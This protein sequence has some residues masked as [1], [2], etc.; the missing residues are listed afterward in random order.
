MFL[1]ARKNRY[2]SLSNRHLQLLEST[3]AGLSPNRGTAWD[4]SRESEDLI[5]ALESKELITR[6][7]TAGKIFSAINL[8]P[9]DI[10]CSY[11][12]PFRHPRV[13]FTDA[14]SFCVAC[15][16]ALLVLRFCS[17]EWILRDQTRARHR[18]YAINAETDV[19]S[20][21]DVAAQFRLLRRFLISS[22]DRCLFFALALAYFMRAHGHFPMFVIGIR[23]A[24]FRPHC[25]VQ[26]GAVAFDNRPDRLGRYTPIL[27]I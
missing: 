10:A 16:K 26:Q 2:S 13:Q 20:T 12:I 3:L 15:L 21:L 17:M 19:E 5:A 14:I 8:P 6:D 4:N 11:D 18:A 23:S 24:P 22:K 27:A 1:D 9:I 7:P 25:W